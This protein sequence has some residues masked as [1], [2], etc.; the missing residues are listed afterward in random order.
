MTEQATNWAKQYTA[1][2]FN[3]VYPT[4]WVVRTIA[5]ANYPEYKYDK[6]LY[7]GKKIV[8]ISCGDG[9]NLPLLINLGFEVYATETSQETVEVL[10]KRFPEV[11]FSVGFNHKHSFPD[12]FFDYAL[13]CGSFYYLEHNTCFKDNLQ[14][15]NRILKNDAILFAS[16][17]TK[18]TYVL[19]S[20]EKLDNN[21]YLIKDD[22]HNFRN[23]YRWQVVNSKEELK[24]TISPFL[25]LIACGKLDDEY[26]G[27]L[28]SNYIMASK[29]IK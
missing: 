27:F 23:G 13:A 3:P 22:P 25:K 24:K 8:D 12:N 26:F 6:S 7:L 15:L 9:R 19:R 18:D 1:T 29:N 21:E 11:K 14:E 5:G 20:A 4:E 10:S 16:M 2:K 28:I 17:V